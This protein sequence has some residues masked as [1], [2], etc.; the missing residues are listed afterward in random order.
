LV[1]VVDD[2]PA[3]LDLLTRSLSKEGYSVRTAQSGQDALMLARELKP[4]LITLDVMMPSMDGWSV[5]TALKAD[6]L[7]RDIPVVMVSIVDDKPLGFALGAADYLTK[8]IDRNR[9]TE[10]LAK[11]AP[12]SEGR[13]ALVID[14]LP[15]NRGVLRHGL[16]REG[17]T[18]IEAENGRAGLDLFTER[19]PNLILLDLMMPVMDGF[20]F[21]R[22]LRYRD[23]GRSVP[24]VVVTAKELTTAERDI[25]RAC[26]EN[27][28]LKGSLGP[29]SLLTEIRTKIAE[30]TH[31]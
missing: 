14:D 24:V 5:L 10:V 12:R 8:P 18:V 6:P 22:E 31:P 19:K 9:L 16:E 1:L 28:V 30:A 13:L 27:V 4:R 26:V 20:E 17:W 7:T 23:D 21:L 25:L 11:H 3:V 29:D 15:D 2:D